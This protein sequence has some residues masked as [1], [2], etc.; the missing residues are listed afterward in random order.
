MYDLHTKYFLND[1][2]YVTAGASDTILLIP[3]DHSITEVYSITE[4]E[5][6]YSRGMHFVFNSLTIVTLEWYQTSVFSAIMTAI[7]FI[8]ICISFGSATG[9]MATLMAAIQA[10]TT[11]AITAAVWALIQQLLVGYLIS[12]ALKLFAKAV[13]G[14]MAVIISIIAMAYAAYDS[15]N[16]GGV[17]GAPWAQ[18]LLQIST[19]LTKAVMSNL[20][21]MMKNLLSEYDTFNVF[22]DEAEKQLE[23]ANKLLEH[24]NWLNPLI[25]FGEKPEDYYNRTVH[26]GNIGIAGISAISSYV[27]TALTLPKLDQSIGD[28]TYG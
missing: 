19:G 1:Q 16:S 12:Y 13:G 22:K 8:I 18:T 26:S 4:R 9:P 11:A 20:Q 15:Y 25:I 7:S 5:T 21:D 28:V 6:L 14:E 10:G 2:Y 23:A 27:D 17:E 24:R 3:L